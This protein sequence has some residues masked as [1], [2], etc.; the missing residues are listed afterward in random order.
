MKIPLV[1]TKRINYP[2]LYIFL[3]ITYSIFLLIAVC[4]MRFL[5]QK[6]Y[7]I[8]YLIQWY[9]TFHKVKSPGT[10]DVIQFSQCNVPTT[11]LYQQEFIYCFG[12][13]MISSCYHTVP[14]AIWEIFSE[15]L[16]FCSLLIK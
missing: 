10:S 3:L 4:I 11:K 2:Y 9:V 8:K 5:I 14:S 7:L 16:I 6:V 12:S 1:I 15:F 13:M